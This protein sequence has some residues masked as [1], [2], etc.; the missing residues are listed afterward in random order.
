MKCYFAKGYN[1]NGKLISRDVFLNLC[2]GGKKEENRLDYAINWAKIF[3]TQTYQNCEG[4]N[5]NQAV[6]YEIC[7][8]STQKVV[9]TITPKDCKFVYWNY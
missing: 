4:G 1:C 8:C 3:L 9:K 7:E 2:C 6:K 5:P